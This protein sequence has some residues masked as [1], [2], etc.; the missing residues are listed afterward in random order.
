MI[1]LIFSKIDLAKANVS[2]SQWTNNFNPVNR[3]R[4]T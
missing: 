2:T 1:Q 4:R 3:I